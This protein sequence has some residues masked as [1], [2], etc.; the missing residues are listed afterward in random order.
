MA[1]FAEKLHQIPLSEMENYH[2]TLK[3][4]TGGEGAYTIELSHY[5]PAPPDTQKKLIDGFRQHTDD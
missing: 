2:S 4:I 5:E 3:S 1:R